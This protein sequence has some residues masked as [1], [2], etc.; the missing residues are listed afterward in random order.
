MTLVSDELIEAYNRKNNFFEKR[1]ENLAERM[2]KF[3]QENQI[4]EL[5]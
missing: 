5:T 2:E 1:A 3:H 4:Y